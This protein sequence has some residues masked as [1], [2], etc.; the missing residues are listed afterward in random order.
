MH[1]TE[2]TANSGKNYFEDTIRARITAPLR[3]IPGVETVKDLVPQ[4]WR[5]T[6][7]NLLQKS[8]Y[9]KSIKQQYKAPNM[10]IGTRKML[11][12]KFYQPNQEL[13][14]FL[15]RDLSNWSY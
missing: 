7:Y 5:D 9:G 8:T 10:A 13:A 3:S 11:L 12:E 14:N 15:N 4:Q 6:A 1:Q 2:V